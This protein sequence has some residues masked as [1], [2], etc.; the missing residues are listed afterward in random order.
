MRQ[1]VHR[2]PRPAI[3]L[4]LLAGWVVI[5]IGTLAFGR[6]LLDAFIEATFWTV[7]SGIA[8]VFELRRT[9]R[10]KARLEEKGQI[11]AFLRYPDA[12]P[13]SLSGIWNMGIATPRAERIDFQP[14][15]YDTL[16]P[17][18]RSTQIKI[19]EVLPGS[20]PINSKDRKYIG[21][22]DDLQVMSL[23]TDKGKV[24]IAASPDSLAKLI[25]G[26]AE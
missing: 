18:G 9:R 13:G 22:I 19:L 15:V 4:A 1:W 3:A 23:L 20:R 11:R 21:G 26:T 10:V 24:E 2:N 12:L 25:A 16:E 14:A 8:L 5:A 17:S 7:L 6:P